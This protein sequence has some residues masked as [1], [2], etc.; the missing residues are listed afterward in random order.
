[1]V[2]LFPVSYPYLKKA[3]TATLQH[4]W[5]WVLAYAI[6]KLQIHTPRPYFL[7]S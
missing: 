4:I 5:K 2:P 3:K 1:M 7:S 6:I